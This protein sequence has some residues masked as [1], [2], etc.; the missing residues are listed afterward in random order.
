M[1]SFPFFGF[2]NDFGKH[3]FSMIHLNISDFYYADH[4]NDE[5]FEWFYYSSLSE[6]SG[7]P[8][9]LPLQSDWNFFLDPED[10]FAATRS[11]PD[12][13]EFVQWADTQV[14]R[15]QRFLYDVLGNLLFHVSH[16]HL[17]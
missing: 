2:H 5:Q 4:D 13:H 11:D 3:H 6:E 17:E 12:Y 10:E 14:S 1:P 16:E 15:P 8:G 7:R 9:D